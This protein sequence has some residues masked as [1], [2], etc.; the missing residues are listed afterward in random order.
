MHSIEA[1]LSLIR[2]ISLA[3]GKVAVQT[4][5][6]L[7]YGKPV[8]IFSW[9]YTHHQLTTHEIFIALRSIVHLTILTKTQ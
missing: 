3:L 1:H 9:T 4:A 6:N 8:S 2:L 5:A 7:F